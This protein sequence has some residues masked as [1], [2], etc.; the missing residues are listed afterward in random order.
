M[1]GQKIAKSNPQTIVD[2]AELAKRYSLDGL[3]AYLISCTVGGQDVN[4]S[5]EKLRA[6]V[7]DVL[8]NSVGNLVGR[9][10]TLLAKHFPEGVTRPQKTPEFATRLVK[11][12]D[13]WLAQ[14]D[15]FFAEG[16]I[17]R[18]CRACFEFSAVLNS[19][20]QNCAPWHL[21]EDE[22][23]ATLWWFHGFLQ[24]LTILLSVFAPDL[25]ANARVVLC[26]PEQALLEYCFSTEEE[27]TRAAIKSKPLVKKI[28]V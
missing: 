8:A 28:E 10:S 4:F 18:A 7:N 16:E 23:S 3:R 14:V 9:L 25:S 13:E 21:A 20:F 26:L 5:E 27:C 24:D 17:S 15:Q 1:E 2:P 6:T 11:T 19:E 22:Q 12:R